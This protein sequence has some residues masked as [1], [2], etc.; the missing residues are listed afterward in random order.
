MV[1]LLKI[2]KKKN[3]DKIISEEVNDNVMDHLTAGIDL[4]AGRKE[5]FFLSKLEYLDE[6]ILKPAF[7]I[8]NTDNAMLETFEKLAL[9]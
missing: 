8:Q 1:N 6:N 7:C 5:N 2:D 3:E 9:S 4:I